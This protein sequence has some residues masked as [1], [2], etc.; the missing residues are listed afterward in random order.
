[1]FV[2]SETI[3]QIFNQ[4]FPYENQWMVLSG[5]SG[6]NNTTRYIKVN[7][8][9]YILRIYETH[10]DEEKVKF[11]HE[12]LIKLNEIQDVPFKVPQPIFTEKGET[13]LRLQDGSN[14]I[15]CLYSYIDGE[16]PNF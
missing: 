5:K 9:T 10:K 2:T 13:F 12:V 14:K 7:N 11:E 3:G 15:A 16:N 8:Q 1:M 6:Y 4:F